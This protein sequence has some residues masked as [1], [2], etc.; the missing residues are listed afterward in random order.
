MGIAVCYL[1]DAMIIREKEALKAR[2]KEAEN[3]EQN[4]VGLEISKPPTDLNASFFVSPRLRGYYQH[5]LRLSA[6]HFH[7]V[8]AREPR[9]VS[10]GHGLAVCLSLLGHHSAAVLTYEKVLLSLL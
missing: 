3:G 8:L 2:E 9:N 1:H 10:A 6:Q 4:R 5:Y 7:D